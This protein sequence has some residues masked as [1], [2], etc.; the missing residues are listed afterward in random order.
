MTWFCKKIKQGEILHESAYE[1]GIK[2]VML[3][4]CKNLYYF[5]ILVF[6][7]FVVVAKSPDPL[8]ID[9]FF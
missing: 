8:H 5:R 1:R 7:L 2:E 6:F 3:T 4:K 9:I